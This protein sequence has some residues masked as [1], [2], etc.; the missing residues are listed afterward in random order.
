MEKDFYSGPLGEPFEDLSVPKG[1]INVSGSMECYFHSG[2]LLR[3][4]TP[5]QRQLGKATLSGV[6]RHL[7]QQ[8]VDAAVRNSIPPITGPRRR[9]LVIAVR[10]AIAH[11]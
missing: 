2:T 8:S 11:W 7:A 6:W 3:L 4:L 9:P 5:S 10:N 1:V